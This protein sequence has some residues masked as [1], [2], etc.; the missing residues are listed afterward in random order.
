MTI[1]IQF[2]DAAVD[3]L[4]TFYNS[5]ELVAQTVDEMTSNPGK[6]KKSLMAIDEM[7]AGIIEKHGKNR[8]NTQEG[9]KLQQLLDKF[10]DAIAKLLGN[11]KGKDIKD[12]TTEQLLDLALNDITT[13]KPGSSFAEMNIPVGNYKYENAAANYRSQLSASQ[14][15]E[16]NMYDALTTV[17]EGVKGDKSARQAIDDAYKQVADQMTEKEF[18]T[19]L[20]TLWNQSIV[21]NGKL[22][23]SL[24]VDD[25]EDVSAEASWT[26]I[27]G[28]KTRRL[29]VFTRQPKGSTKEEFDALIAEKHRKNAEFFDKHFDEYTKALPKGFW[30]M[31]QNYS[32]DGEFQANASALSEAD[33]QR[34]IDAAEEDGR[35]WDNT[36]DMALIKGTKKLESTYK[37]DGGIRKAGIKDLAKDKAYN[38]RVDQNQ[39]VMFAFGDAIQQLAEA[40][41]DKTELGSLTRSFLN[42]DKANANIFRRSAR[43][44]GY[45]GNLEQASRHVPEHNPPAG[46]IAQFI[47][48]Y[49][50]K[51]QFNEE[52]KQAIRDKFGYW[53]ID[54]AA[55]P[56]GAFIAAAT[57]DFNLLTD[58]PIVRYLAAGVDVTGLKL[59]NGKT[60]AEEKGI[61]RK[62]VNEASKEE[63]TKAIALEVGVKPEIVN[64]ISESRILLSLIQNGIVKPDADT[65]R[66]PY[67]GYN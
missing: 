14:K 24:L 50:S 8:L 32:K 61:D 48:E 6:F 40:G 11:V 44:V 25:A 56:Q 37:K 51:G 36:D 15:K 3:L 13:G 52:A 43:L 63:L 38:E 55:D 30:R 67:D 20:R 27:A 54:H 5:P 35:T 29:G 60:L 2:G 59:F 31:L 22:Q 12:L 57:K 34:F 64:P 39:D 9:S 65:Q 16:Q 19:E 46:Y 18:L 53:Q 21:D 10:W 28:G 1:E 66:Y 17:L 47:Y 4:T 58:D 62:W 23:D 41:V 7:F 42:P 33:A 45:S 26:K 49:A